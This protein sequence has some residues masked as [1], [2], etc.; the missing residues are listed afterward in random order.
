MSP[1]S[2]CL[3]P[4]P[5]FIQ[6]VSPRRAAKVRPDLGSQVSP[7]LVLQLLGSRGASPGAGQFSDPWKLLPSWW[8]R[9]GDQQ[10]GLLAGSTPA[11]VSLGRPAGPARPPPATAL[12][13]VQD[14]GSLGGWRVA[15]LGSNLN[16]IY[17][18]L[19]FKVMYCASPHSCPH[20][21]D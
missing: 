16:F 7:F 13:E 11:L 19:F 14:S 9:A 4:E 17:I 20:T 21:R 12:P 2:T 15:G 6:S 3:D 1:G 18:T 10:D 8:G 5:H